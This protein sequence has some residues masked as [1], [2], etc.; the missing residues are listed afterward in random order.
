MAVTAALAYEN[1]LTNSDSL[2]KVLLSNAKAILTKMA[3]NG[4]TTTAMST[5]NSVLEMLPFF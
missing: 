2:A 5:L 4:L 3:A 1:L